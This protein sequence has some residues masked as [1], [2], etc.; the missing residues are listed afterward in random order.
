[1][2]EAPLNPE[3]TH[4]MDGLCLRRISESEFMAPV[5]SRNLPKTFGG[6]VVAQC[7]ASVQ[8]VTLPDRR[9]HSLHSH[10]LRA[11]NP[12][13]PMV[14][15]V[16]D[17]RQ[18]GQFTFL[19]VTASQGEET[20]Y[21]MMATAHAAPPEDAFDH[22]EPHDAEG[23]LETARSVEEWVPVDSVTVPQWWSSAGPLT[24]RFEQRPIGL[25]GGDAAP[26][27]LRA[28]IRPADGRSLSVDESAALLAYASDLSLLDVAMHPFG[29]SW[30]S[31]PD[32][33]GASLDHSMWLHR[34]YV[35]ADWLRYELHSPVVAKGRAFV[36]G[37]LRT[38]EGA[39]VASVAQEGLIAAVR[40]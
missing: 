34:P 39:L 28:W 19:D 27:D 6:Q 22:D 32:V 20:I 1:M 17:T 18:G 16:Q 11:G 21:R 7:L 30:Y 37:E 29:Q 3:L 14:I 38:R 12:T 24:F 8:A 31:E 13:Q 2:G 26:A 4:L 5:I 25:V 23:A 33:F 9:L 15:R 35:W 40:Q 10:F 36:R